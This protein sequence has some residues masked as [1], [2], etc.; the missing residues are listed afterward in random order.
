MTNGNRGNRVGAQDE[1]DA[2]CR[3]LFRKCGAEEA[4]PLFLSVY[5]SWS[6]GRRCLDLR[7]KRFAALRLPDRLFPATDGEA[8]D[9]FLEIWR[10][11]QE[12]GRDTKAAALDSSGMGEFVRARKLLQEAGINEPLDDFVRDALRETLPKGTAVT[13]K[14]LH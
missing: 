13:L 2:T 10:V 12:H 4:F 14:E 6:G 9:K 11:M 7:G 1:R 8:V 5:K 3:P